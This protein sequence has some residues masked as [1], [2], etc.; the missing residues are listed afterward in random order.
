MLRVET[1]DSRVGDMVM[2]EVE[3]CVVTEM[4]TYSQSQNLV[5]PGS[6]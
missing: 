4:P 5:S 2:G 6:L 3:R 1:G